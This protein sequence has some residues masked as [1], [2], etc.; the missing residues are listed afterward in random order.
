[1]AWLHDERKCIRF[2]FLMNS[3]ILVSLLVLFRPVAET[4]D[5]MALAMF[6]NGAR[7]FYDAHLIYSNYLLGC[8]LAG[9][10][11]VAGSVVWAFVLQYFVLFCSFTAIAYVMLCRLKNQI[12][13]WLSA[14]VIYFFAYEGYVH[15][16]F[17]KTAGIAT[18]AGVFLLFY[19]IESEKT[20]RKAWIA[21]YLLTCAGFM[22][23][24]QQ[25]LVVFA[26][27]SGI[28]VFWLFNV[29]RDRR[30]RIRP[31]LLRCAGVFAGLAILIGGLF[32]ADR[33]AY[34]SQGWQEY[35]EY[36]K[37]LTELIDYGFPDY[38]ENRSTYKE[39][40]INRN[41]YLLY[42]RWNYADTE[43]FTP[44]IMRSLVERKPEKHMSLQTIKDFLLEVPPGFL[45]RFCFWCFLLVFAGWLFW[46]IHT[47]NAFA[48]LI[49]E[50][51]LLG[52]VYLYL[53]YLGRYLYNR[54]DVGLWIAAIL[55]LL[56]M[57]RPGDSSF[58][59]KLG[60]LA[61]LPV[62]C[63]T[64]AV[65]KDSWRWNTEPKAQ[66]MQEMRTV[67]TDIYEDTEHIY[68]AKSGT[69]SYS[70]CYDVFEAMP[71]GIAQNVFSLGGWPTLTPWYF[72]KLESAGIDNPYRDMIG[73]DKV[74]LIDQDID[75]TLKY[76]RKY[77]DKTVRAN[78]IRECS[79][80][81]TYQIAR[82]D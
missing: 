54:V 80:Y 61:F 30:G 81:G 45:K 26:L 53:Y 17:T 35:F 1:M 75:S 66:R 55:L 79:G 38:R 68:L 72:E 7:G 46:G 13:I 43:K 49:Y 15:L 63:L 27:M 14:V 23:R 77:Y 82:G 51:L 28:G 48:A 18:A 10:Y 31:M 58:T 50:I 4:N 44:E 16:Q 29:I 36:N 12:A 67:L 76:L 52:A 59:N 20:F 69:I 24:M 6:A 47:G 42:R 25:F 56:W 71:V 37:Q 22:Y 34:R 39:L 41:A 2:A 5:D 33:L 9:L 57:F 8:I 32:A 40:G 62:L 73:N 65:W 60:L 74:Y 64:Q 70:A 11:R 78:L 3:V 19:V 21:G